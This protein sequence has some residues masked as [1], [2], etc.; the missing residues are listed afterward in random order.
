MYFPGGFCISFEVYMRIVFFDVACPS[1][2]SPNPSIRC[3]QVSAFH[4]EVSAMPDQHRCLDW[5]L[6][7]TCGDHVLFL[8]LRF[9]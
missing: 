9:R 6:R 8:R 3:G 1:C 2:T 7:M 4:G 5:I